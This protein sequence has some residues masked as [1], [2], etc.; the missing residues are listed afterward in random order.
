MA[1][2]DKH[3]EKIDAIYQKTRNEFSTQ[4]CWILST[5][6][7][8]F[9]GQMREYIQQ[10]TSDKVDQIVQKLEQNAPLTQ[11]DLE[12]IKLWVVGDAD[13]YVKME[14]NYND[15]VQEL[16]RLMKEYQSMKKDEMDFQEAA[17]LR[18]MLLDGVRVL[19]DI[20]FF[21]KQKERLRNFTSS[22]EE[23][24]PQERDLLIRLLKGKKISPNE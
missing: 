13:Y 23:I 22:V 4:N 11:D 17:K 5:E 3:F 2:L 15:W 24:D 12:Y 8:A 19:G 1:H 9:E 14:N 16:D 10:T 21:L 18:A 6:L 20:V 7:S